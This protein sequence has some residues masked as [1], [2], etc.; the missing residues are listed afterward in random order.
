M[1]FKL[2]APTAGNKTVKVKFNFEELKA[3][4]EERL[5]LYKNRH[6]DMTN[7]TAEAKKDRAALNRLK[8]AINEAKINIKKEILAHYESDFE[9]KVKELLAMIEDSSSEIDAQIKAVEEQAKAEKRQRLEAYY[10]TTAKELG[11]IIPFG[12]IFND[13][14][15][16][17]T[18]AEET[19]ITE[20]FN[21]IGKIKN[22]LQTLEANVSPEFSVEVKDVYFSTL[23]LGQALRRNTYLLDQKKKQEEYAAKVK[24]EQEAKKA[25]EAPK[26][27]IPPIPQSAEVLKPAE[28]SAPSAEQAEETPLK[29]IDFRVWVTEEQKNALRA[30]LV[31]NKIK[32]GKVR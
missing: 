5:A 1:E 3:H 18:Y 21:A 29:Q 31:E 14:W 20:I 28:E 10:Y 2:L 26:A 16:N 25:A 27:N 23:D 7:G 30:F 15:L 32:F 6:Y 17:A 9:P 12:N 22:D 4:L 19:A 13:R 8:K 24:A 11:K